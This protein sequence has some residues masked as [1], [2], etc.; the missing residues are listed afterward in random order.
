VW[1]AGREPLRSGQRLRTAAVPRRARR[2]KQLVTRLKV[3]LA[4]LYSLL[5]SETSVQGL[6]APVGR[7]WAY[8][9]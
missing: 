4:A 3:R 5:P 2:S 8:L 9:E 6:H 1:A 7:A